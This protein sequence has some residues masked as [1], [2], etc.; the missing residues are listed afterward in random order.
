MSW[1]DSLFTGQNSSLNSDIAGTGQAASTLTNQGEKY[2]NKAGDWWSG[3]LNGDASKVSKTL[4]PYITDIKTSENQD[5]KSGAEFGT[6]SGGTAASA[7]ANTDK[8]HSD[9]TKL[10]GSLTGSAA[11][12]LGSLGT[13]MTGQGLQ[14]YSENSQ[15]SQMRIQNWHNSILGQGIGAATGKAE[16]YGLNSLF[17]SRTKKKKDDNNQNNTTD[18]TGGYAETQDQA[19]TGFFNDQGDYVSGSQG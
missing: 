14:A 16:A 19:P 9:V 10:I 17:S 2:S 8:A 7:A 1:F 4:S 13:S 11:S 12:S 15:E 5:N 3:I 6:R 18:A